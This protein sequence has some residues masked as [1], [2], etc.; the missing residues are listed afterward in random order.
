[1]SVLLGTACAHG[2][3][4]GVPRR[5]EEGHHAAVGVDVIRTDMLRDTTGFTGRHLGLA[6]VVE[7]RGLAVVDVSHDRDHRRPRLRRTLVLG[8][9]SVRFSSS[10][11][12]LTSLTL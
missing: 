3:K 1:M 12:A 8:E 5:I 6:D 9:V 10:A 7:E 11:S 4:R 2:R